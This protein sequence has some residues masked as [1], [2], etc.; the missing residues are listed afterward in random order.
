MHVCVGLSVM[1]HAAWT[2][3]SFIHSFIHSFI[4]VV[5]YNYDLNRY[6]LFVSRRFDHYRK[7]FPQESMSV[8][9]G[10][11]DLTLNES[12]Q[13]RHLVRRIVMHE[14]YLEEKPRYDIMLLELNT[15]IEFNNKTG[16]IC[17]DASV[18]PPKTK[19]TVTGWGSTTIIG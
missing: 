18:F 2:K 19:C 13:R 4:N 14:K 17:V 12:S 6:P 15:S 7:E 9:V 11:H 1:G 5:Y 16:P 10:E 3:S 8:V